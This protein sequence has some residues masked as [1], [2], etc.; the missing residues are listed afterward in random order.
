MSSDRGAQFTLHLWTCSH[1]MHIR[2]NSPPYHC[3]PSPGQRDSE[4]FPPSPQIS[5]KSMPYWSRMDSRT[6]IG[7]PWHMNSNKDFDLGCSSVELVYGTK[8]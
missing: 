6:I 7:T 3:L 5:S 2:N 4:M 1:F 8:T